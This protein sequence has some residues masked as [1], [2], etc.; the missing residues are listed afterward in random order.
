MRARVAVLIT[1]VA[2]GAVGCQSSGGGRAEVVG[3]PVEERLRLHG[4]AEVVVTLVPEAMGSPAF[5][6]AVR[7]IET[8]VPAGGF[9]VRHRLT[10]I[11]ALAGELTAIGLAPLSDDPAVLRI[12]LD[13]P[14][15]ATLAES[16][17]LMGARD[18]QSY[19][20]TGWGVTV[21]VIDTGT[22]ITH[23]DFSGA[24]V[25]EECVCTGCC[26]DGSSRQSGYGSSRDGHGHGTNVAGIVL[27]RGSV[28][29]SG[30]APGA[31]LVSIKVLSDSGSGSGA[32]SVAALEYLL[33]SQPDVRIVNMSL[34][35]PSY[36]TS[37]ACDY[38]DAF[39]MAYARAIDGLRARGTLVFAAAGNDGWSDGI[40]LPACIQNA[41]AVG[42]VY[43]ASY[44]GI[45]WTT[46]TDNSTEA[47]QVTCFSDSAANVDLL[48]PGAMI[49]A[50]GVG[51]GISQM[52]GTSQATPHA[53]G[54]AALLWH[55]NP[56]ISA[57]TV[58]GALKATGV[59]VYDPRNGLS[60]PRIDVYGAAVLV[61]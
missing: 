5:E 34:G 33:G 26:P 17:S 37:G 10:R 41:V 47:D 23:P 52:G 58:E 22:D 55:V 19:G 16:A 21:A 53:A 60:L 32:D 51:G 6:E 9:A 28:A 38:L 15:R 24:I 11:G 61:Q 3:D 12:D 44:G 4:R 56:Y 13:Q 39:T 57:D 42:A 54:A 31:S 27:G 1:L 14:V 7:R 50:A 49:N 48:A 45:G 40:G 29:S 43:D 25:A 8:V 46:C 2:A 20:Y 36:H 35:S 30:I 59:S 18:V